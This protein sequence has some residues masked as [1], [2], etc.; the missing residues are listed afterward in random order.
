MPDINLKKIPTILGL[1]LLLVGV[2]AGVY[3]VASNQSLDLF[4][5]AG[6]TATPR[7]IKVSNIESDGATISWV[8]DTRVK[9]FVKYG[10][11]KNSL[12]STVA[13]DRDQVSGEG[14]QYT[15]HYVSLNNLKA[16]QEY[17]YVIGSG[18]QVYQNDGQPYQFKTAPTLGGKPAADTINGKIVVASGEPA[19]G[20]VVYVQIQ[21]GSLRSALSKD[22]GTWTLPLA[23]TRTK[24]LSQYLSY[25]RQKERLTITAQGGELGTATAQVYSGQASPVPD[26]KLGETHN[27]L[28]ETPQQVAEP[29]P[30]PTI[31]PTQEDGEEAET[32]S[33]GFKDLSDEELSG[34]DSV[35]LINPSQDG[36]NVATSSPA[37]QVK[38]PVG[39]KVTITVES[40]PQTTEGVIGE[41]GSYIWTPPE[42]LEP[43]EHTVT[44][45]YEDDNGILQ[46][47]KRSFTV[48]AAEDS[49]DLPS[50]TATESATPTLTPTPTPTA[51]ESARTTMPST[52]SGVPD[53]GTMTPTLLILLSGIFLFATG[54]IWQIRLSKVKNIQ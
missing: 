14:S 12:D 24:D 23:T 34:S 42:D 52:E 1:L 26:I 53:A 19:P 50:I 39:K 17:F 38:G 54:I 44:I 20:T 49:D 47:I 35:T 16:N 45:E 43:G 41:D 15:T 30:T 4:S 21:G 18:S 48:L 31:T 28:D 37:L 7:Q 51:T 22:S 6:P 27:F 46:T 8:T 36:E 13:D 33:A 11:S 2:G 25:D 32:E 10:T 5:K 9:G 29:T 40:E 3:L